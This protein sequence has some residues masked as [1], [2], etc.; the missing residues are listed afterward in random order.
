MTD[1]ARVV[2]SG[3]RTDPPLTPDASDE[4]ER[5]SRE[6]YIAKLA[7]EIEAEIAASEIDRTLIP[8]ET[9]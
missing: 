2:W 7:R 5:P 4:L 1:R 8:H 6:T 3:L 9:S